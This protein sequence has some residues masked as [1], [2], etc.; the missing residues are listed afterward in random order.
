M[1]LKKYL[2]AVTLVSGAIVMQQGEGRS[3]DAALMDACINFSY[4]EDE[5]ADINLVKQEEQ[6]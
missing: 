1:K 2:F 5:V 6:L 3:V 4:S